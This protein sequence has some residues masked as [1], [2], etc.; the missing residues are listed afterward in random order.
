[1]V[2]TC[3]L[4][5]SCRSFF[6]TFTSRNETGNIEAAARD[7]LLRPRERLRQEGDEKNRGDNSG[8]ARLSLGRDVQNREGRFRY[9]GRNRE[10]AASISAISDYARTLRWGVA[11]SQDRRGR[12]CAQR[13]AL[14]AR[15]SQH[16]LGDHCPDGERGEKNRRHAQRG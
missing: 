13:R 1:G 4:P 16:A 10:R 6:T 9:R 15:V 7:R 3:A 12:G 14:S 11:I 8:R 2:Q 5:I